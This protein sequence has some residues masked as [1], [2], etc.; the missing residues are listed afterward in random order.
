LIDIYIII[1]NRRKGLSKKNPI[2]A[3]LTRLLA[4]EPRPARPDVKMP[5]R[6]GIAQAVNF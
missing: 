6:C 5:G 2:M 1:D 3:A 4:R